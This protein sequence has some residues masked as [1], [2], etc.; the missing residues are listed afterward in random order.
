MAGPLPLRLFSC[1]ASLALVSGAGPP[2]SVR[3]DFKH[4]LWCA[5]GPAGTMCSLPGLRE[6]WAP[7]PL[8]LLL[9]GLLAAARPSWADGHPPGEIGA[10]RRRGRRVGWKGRG[11]V[12]PRGRRAW[13]ARPAAGAGERSAAAGDRR[14][15]P[16]AASSCWPR[17]GRTRGLGRLGFRSSGSGIWNQQ[18]LGSVRGVLRVR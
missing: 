3:R 10:G 6:A 13:P 5:E 18:G 15:R 14:W 17:L 8:P 1:V 12:R 7:P 11:T 2:A 16:E 9:L 4:R